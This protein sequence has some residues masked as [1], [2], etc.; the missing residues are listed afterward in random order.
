MYIYTVLN[1]CFVSRKYVSHLLETCFVRVPNMF[2]SSGKLIPNN[3]L[4]KFFN[5]FA[6]FPLE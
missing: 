3:W 2:R 5:F 1:L 6:V 4:L